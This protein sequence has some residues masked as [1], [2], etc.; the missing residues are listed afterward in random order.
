MEDLQIIQGL[1]LSDNGG[2]PVVTI[3]GCDMSDG[4]LKL[5][6]KLKNHVA[7]EIFL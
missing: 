4:E 6:K 2:S 5:R 3:Y 1:L 7:I